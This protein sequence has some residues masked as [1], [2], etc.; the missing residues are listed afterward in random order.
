MSTQIKEL[1]IQA[2]AGAPV[3]NIENGYVLTHPEGSLY[4]EPH[5][6]L[7]PEISSQQLDAVITPV[8]NVAL[9]L[10]GTFLRGKKVPNPMKFATNLFTGL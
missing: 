8:V 3:P 1:T 5:G 10:A 4:V 6:F 7:D 9:P 2:T